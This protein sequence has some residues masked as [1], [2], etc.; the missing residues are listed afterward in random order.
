MFL[1]FLFNWVKQERTNDT[2]RD[3][4]EKNNQTQLNV[5]KMNNDTALQSMR[6]QTAASFAMQKQ[7]QDF[8]ARYNSAE[9]QV[10]R[11]R[12]AGLNPA[13]TVDGSGSIST[14]ANSA[15]SVPGMSMP[16]FNTPNMVAPQA[17]FSI[18]EAA[19]AIKN[20][21][22][23][24][25]IGIE[26][27]YRA[28]QLINELN[29]QQAEINLLNISFDE[30]QKMKD[31]LE[32][33]K[34]EIKQRVTFNQE[35]RERNID[36]QNKNLR[37]LD[38]AHNEAAQEYAFNEKVN[39][40]KLALVVAQGQEA[41]ANAEQARKAGD[42]YHQAALAAQKEGVLKDKESK[43]KD[44]EIAFQSDPTIIQ[45]RKDMYSSDEATR[46][47]AADQAEAM[48]RYY[49]EAGDSWLAEKTRKWF[50]LMPDEAA[51]AAGN[52]AVAIGIAKGMRSPKGKATAGTVGRSETT[53]LPNVVGQAER[54]SRALRTARTNTKAAAS[55]TRSRINSAN[56]RLATARKN[57]ANSKKRPI[58]SG[59]T[60]TY[61]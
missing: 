16:S 14:G 42:Y 45:L 46:R 25:G 23:A 37:A 44:I 26:N 20:L 53:V 33:Q 51:S 19:E 61:R 30:K 15:A 56:E 48:A 40:K 21:E 35:D 49:Q 50:G 58:Y 17:N 18:G 8:N 31:Y 12:A 24:K 55:A 1:D 43:L 52:T 47:A 3:I 9:A 27:D 39:P 28:S 59:N 57:R 32:A 36:A 60:Y 38:D 11:A 10:Q 29:R 41:R 13:L 4:A 7:N 5:A 54:N 34:N 6:E 2:N 22:D